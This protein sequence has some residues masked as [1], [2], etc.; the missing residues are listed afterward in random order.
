MKLIAKTSLLIIATLGQACTMQPKFELIQIESASQVQAYPCLVTLSD[1]RLMVV[2]S[3]WAPSNREN[4][5][6]AT[7]YSQDHG[8]TWSEPEVLIDSPTEMDYDP[9]ITVM[10]DVLVVTSTTTPRWHTEYI[11]PSR[12]VAVWMGSKV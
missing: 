12:T 6:V 8:R 3:T 5:A 10:D 1:N 11:S 7:I 2:Y 4:M 9:N